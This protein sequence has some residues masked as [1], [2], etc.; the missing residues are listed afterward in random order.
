MAGGGG[1]RRGG[2]LLPHPRVRS[3]SR[4]RSGWSPPAARRRSSRACRRA[5][6]AAAPARPP[7]PLPT[8]RE[9]NPPGASLRTTN[10][11]RRRAAPSPPAPR[12]CRFLAARP[13][14]V[15][16]PRRR[17]PSWPP[18]RRCR[19]PRRRRRRRGLCCVLMAAAGRQFE[20]LQRD[21]S[22][23]SSGARLWNTKVPCPSKVQRFWICLS[24]RGS[25][26][27]PTCAC[28]SPLL[29]T[30]RPVY[31]RRAGA[32]PPLNGRATRVRHPWCPIHPSLRTCRS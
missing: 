4:G 21:L 31:H 8:G 1:R 17:P 13:P 3:M 26:G 6:V 25:S 29:D 14:M 5:A 27:T 20:N 22:L 16:L 9:G 30:Q 28:D 7:Q 18:L 19:R 2:N 10:A 32:A 11:R 12:R 24:G 23:R 15:T